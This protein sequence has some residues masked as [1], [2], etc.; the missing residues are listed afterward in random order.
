MVRYIN[1]PR[2]NITR[3]WQQFYPQWAIPKGF[4]VHHIKPRCTFE[5]QNDTRINHP[6]NLI[7]LHPDD[8]Y[9]IHKCRGDSVTKNFITSIVGRKCSEETKQKMS[10]TAQG[11]PSMPQATR[12]KISRSSLGHKRTAEFIK[13]AS[14]SYAEK[15]REPMSA[16]TKAKIS[17]ATTGK[18]KSKLSDETK[19]RMTHGQQRRRMREARPVQIDDIV[20][21]SI[22]DAMSNTG[23]SR[24]K[25][26]K[27]GEFI[28][29]KKI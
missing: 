20:Y 10:K 12:D 9:T 19:A 15:G 1:D 5:D 7:A 21:S 13:K 23:L 27:Y 11:R 18:P 4:H 3:Y 14:R 29:N 25:V 8:H 17:A 16:E 28:D 24:H 22:L 26:E 2:V 6:R